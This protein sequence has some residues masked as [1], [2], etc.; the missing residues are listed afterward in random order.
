MTEKAFEYSES[1]SKLLVDLMASYNLSQGEEIPPK[2][3]ELL[4]QYE[5]LQ[6]QIDQERQS[7]KSEILNLKINIGF[8]D[9]YGGKLRQTQLQI[10]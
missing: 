2:V 4:Q 9:T 8:S 1:R 6:P 5:E 3:Q 7:H 10:I